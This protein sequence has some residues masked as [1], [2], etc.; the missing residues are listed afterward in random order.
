MYLA[1]NLFSKIGTFFNELRYSLSDGL[2]FLGGPLDIAIALFDIAITA[3][4]VYFILLLLRD[5]RAWQL[6][7]GIILIIAFALVSSAVGLNTI[8]FMLNR[9]ISILAIAIIVLF[10]PELRRTLETVGRN[11]LKYGVGNGFTRDPALHR[12]IE[13]IVNACEW[14][15][16]SQTGALIVIERGTKLGELCEQENAVRIDALVSSSLLRQIFY[17]GSPLHDGAV[18]IRDGRVA[19]ARVH[20]A[21][22]DNYHLRRDFGL[23]HRAAVG[24]SEMG[25][26]IAVVVSEE[27]GTISIAIDGV[28]HVLGNADSL[29]THLHRL[30]GLVVDDERR[31]IV[32]WFRRLFRSGKEA[33]QERDREEQHAVAAELETNYDEQVNDSASPEEDMIIE[34]R[35]AGR[36]RKLLRRRSTGFLL[37]RRQR[38]GLAILSVII[39]CFMWVFVQVSV[40]PVTTKMYSVPLAHYGLEEA[41]ERGFGVQNFPVANVQVTLRGRQ[42][43]LES[44]EPGKIAAYIDVSEV[45]RVGLVRLPVIIDTETLLYTRTELLLPDSVA[46]NVYERTS[47]TA[48]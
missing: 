21:L 3:L 7:R 17:V 33:E 12:M 32:G 4:V 43:V 48:D 44:I 34:N 46:V 29:R 18:V 24:A 23:R 1:S 38:M 8:G 10:Q 14:M 13:D 26:A 39:S 6:L 41:H 30:L 47:D 45:S 31:P 19:A 36:K 42:Q 22:S 2:L 11:R 9:T 28:L 27:R 5:S 25:D 20:I 37:T 16:K 40:N 35:S 15:S